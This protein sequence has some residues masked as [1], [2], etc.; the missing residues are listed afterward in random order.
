[1]TRNSQPEPK[2]TLR[3]I[4]GFVVYLFLNPLI[5]FAAA[6]TIRW[7]MAWAFFGVSI[8]AALFS[9]V[10][11][12]RKNPDLLTERGRYR[13]V[14]DVKPWD[15]ILVPVAALYGPLATIVVAGLD[16]RFGW[17]DWFP[18]W[19]QVAALLAGILG[20]WFA[21]WAMVENRF[22]SAVVRIQKDRGHT[23]CQTGPYRWMRHPG[24]A[25]GILWYLITPLVFD[26][27]WSFI[28]ALVS[29]MVTVIRTALEDQTLQA[30]LPGYQAYTRQTR[31][32]LLPGIW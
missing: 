7:G 10:L 31:Y 17:T 25:G 3:A 32:R 23:V 8:F 29:V 4:L 15:K 18:L 9:R 2:I 14:Q 20:L 26:S 5:L 30:E 19:V 13:Q 12:H 1:M 27:A 21:S 28:P 6:G 16:R 24:Y 22:F 11:A